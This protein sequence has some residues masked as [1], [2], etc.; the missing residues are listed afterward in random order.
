MSLSCSNTSIKSLKESF[1][2]SGRL[3]AEYYQ[4][5]YQAYETTILSAKQGYTFVKNEFEPVKEN[6]G[7]EYEYEMEGFDMKECSYLPDFYIPSID[8]WFE[9]K[10]QPLTVSEVQKCEQ[11]CRRKDN[12]NIKFSILI[13]APKPLMLEEEDFSILGIREYTWQWPS[14]M[15]PSDTLLLA[16]GLTGEEYYSR[17]LPAIW[18]VDGV[19]DK[20]LIRAIREARSA[21][22]E[23]GETPKGR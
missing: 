9:I 23:F 15:Y 22:F 8:R 11:F 5:K 16:Q 7:L 21:R 1:L 13:G 19:D 2:H 6:I 12:E 4:E 18:K 10:G 17:F 20:L 14:Q 3:D